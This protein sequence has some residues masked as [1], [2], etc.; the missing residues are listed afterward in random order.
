MQKSEAKQSSTEQ[1]EQS[2]QASKRVFELP[3]LRLELR[4]LTHRATQIFVGAID[5][6]KDIV[7]LVYTVVNLLY[8]PRSGSSSASD[9]SKSGRTIPYSPKVPGTRSVTVVVREADGVAYT[10]G[11]DID[12]DHKEIHFA[13]DH[14]CN[15]A[16]LF[17]DDKAKIR[18]ELIG[19][20]CHE[21][22][23]CYQKYNNVPGGLVEGIADWVRLR[24]ELAP[25]HWEKRGGPKVKWDSGYETT[26]FFLD[27][28]EIKH[29]EGS[30]RR[31]N[32]RLMSER[33]KEA[34]FWNG[35]FGSSVHDLWKQYTASLQDS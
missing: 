10:T 9:K 24:A 20:L 6:S 15:T 16:D 33:Y 2:D 28:I 8:H 23:H 25:P 31:I 26:G 3:K 35:L 18:H 1:S 11:L 29:G 14:I 4:D 21:L 27:W 32:E 30:V 5:P 17:E 34:T 22:V 13:F 12:D 7:N 19:V